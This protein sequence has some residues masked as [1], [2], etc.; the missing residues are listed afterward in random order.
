ME[1]EEYQIFYRYLF[2][3]NEYRYFNSYQEAQ[4][5]VISTIDY[6]NKKVSFSELIEGKNKYDELYNLDFK[7]TK[8]YYFDFYG[9]KY[10]FKDK[11]N[12]MYYIMKLL[13]FKNNLIEIE[14]EQFW[15]NNKFLSNKT[16]YIEYLYSN[17]KEIDNSNAGRLN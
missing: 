17:L 7:Q 9:I 13:N 6:S 1:K 16:D 15:L 5:Y 8:I 2:S 14:V 4:N 11:T 10:Y 12:L 3:N